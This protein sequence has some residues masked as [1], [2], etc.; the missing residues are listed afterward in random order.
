MCLVLL[1]YASS[2]VAG[3]VVWVFGRVG[4]VGGGVVSMP[5]VRLLCRLSRDD[6]SWSIDCSPSLPP[7]FLSCVFSFF[8][9]T[10]IVPE[11][12]STKLG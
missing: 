3:Q 4:G 5:Q 11:R 12:L 1:P 7:G 10:V 6:H 9:V 8:R 2:V